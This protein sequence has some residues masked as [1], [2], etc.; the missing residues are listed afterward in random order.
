MSGARHGIGQGTVVVAVVAAL[1]AITLWLVHEP[2]VAPTLSTASSPEPT[3]ENVPSQRVSAEVEPAPALSD[4]RPERAA[5]PDPIHAEV[6]GRVVDVRGEPIAA[7]EVFLQGVRGG[8]A[9]S[10]SAADGTFT[11]LGEPASGVLVQCVAATAVHLPTQLECGELRAGT[12]RDLGDVVLVAGCPVTG[13]IVDVHG[14]PVANV[15]LFAAAAGEDWSVQPRPASGTTAA[16]GTFALRP[17]L[18]AGRWLLRADPREFVTSALFTAPAGPRGL[19][20]RLTLADL[21]QPKRIIG[22]VVDANGTPVAGVT[23]VVRNEPRVEPVE[24][25]RQGTFRL[26]GWDVTGDALV[27]LV[28]TDGLP[29]DAPQR[30]PWDGDEV[31]LRWTRGTD[32]E[33]VVRRAEDGAVVPNAQVALQP[34]RGADASRLTSALLGERAN[35]PRKTDAAGVATFPEL[36]PGACFVMVTARDLES[37]S[38]PRVV[39]GGAP[40]RRVEVALAAT[41]ERTLTV[42]TVDG[43]PAGRVQVALWR[44]T[45]A[46]APLADTNSMPASV[47]HFRT[48][49]AISLESTHGPAVS[50]AVTDAQG[51]CRLRAPGRLRC[52]LTL[53]SSNYSSKARDDVALAAMPEPWI[54]TVG[55]GGVVEGRVRLGKLSTNA[56]LFVQ[57]CDRVGDPFGQ[58]FLARPFASDG[59]FR[60]AGLDAGSWRLSLMHAGTTRPF[61]EILDLGAHETRHVDVDLREQAD[62]EISGTALWNGRPLTLGFRLARLDAGVAD[63]GGAWVGTDAQ[64]RFQATV[65]P[66]VYRAV[67]RHETGG[68]GELAFAEELTFGPGSRG[69]YELRLHTR[70]VRVRLLRGTHPAAGVQVQAVAD[71]RFPLTFAPTDDYGCAE[72]ALP[73]GTHPLYVL[74]RNAGGPKVSLGALAVVAGEGPQITR[75]TLPD[76]AGR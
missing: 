47:V 39:T 36:V 53:A 5:L 62:A 3:P 27:S 57:R 51:H 60:V 66:G 11:L 46:P 55:D 50:T 28:P 68:S 63:G 6:T 73:L 34:T 42:L 16:D 70:A 58:R 59:S 41:T 64:G 44:A 10:T 15:P 69:R 26:L 14:E 17:V 22:K 74:P 9:T 33:V 40:L 7:A 48:W 32:V 23:V 4:T 75:W 35:Q 2:T 24:S 65:A 54:E 43:R 8:R 13:R 76:D 61:A 45:A 56:V 37:L 72:F 25:S 20:L 12:S 71:E 29:E 30:L 19:E 1:A 38:T 31:L 52:K 18:A 21:R 49:P 67:R